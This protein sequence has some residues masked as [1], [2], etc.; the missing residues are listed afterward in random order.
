MRGALAVVVL[1]DE[2]V[3]RLSRLVS[4]LERRPELC[5]AVRIL[6]LR[7]QAGGTT[8]FWHAVVSRFIK[9]VGAHVSEV[10]IHEL[11]G[12]AP[13]LFR[14]QPRRLVIDFD[15]P[16]M[17]DRCLER[18]MLYRWLTFRAGGGERLVVLELGDAPF[19]IRLVELAAAAHA[20]PR[21]RTLK[22][23]RPTGDTVVRM[24][25]ALGAHIE[26][27]H[28][29]H[30]A[31]PDLSPFVGVLD[32]HLDNVAMGPMSG[33]DWIRGPDGKL[34]MARITRWPPRLE[35]LTIYMT[36]PD[37][38][39][40]YGDMASRLRSDLIEDRACIRHIVLATTVPISEKQHAAATRG[41]VRHL[42]NLCSEL[43]IDLRCVR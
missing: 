39:E 40:A 33:L 9:L 12:R 7:T 22:L 35:A 25:R 41:R 8:A 1:T 10:R 11:F 19:L 34:S 38:V 3:P 24:A 15:G 20:L 21:V 30:C 14:L 37:P 13:G 43:S 5:T 29:G 17:P 36:E 2:R 31:L 18:E 6:D 4:L 32:L 16:I 23:R 28:L 27:L 42:A 26:A